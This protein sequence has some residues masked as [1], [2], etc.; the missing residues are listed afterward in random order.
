MKAK[1]HI[2]KIKEEHDNCKSCPEGHLHSQIGFLLKYFEAMERIAIMQT[3]LATMNHMGP[4]GGDGGYYGQTHYVSGE[5]VAANRVDEIFEK[6]MK[7][8]QREI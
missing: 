2:A 1:D 8:E 4:T 5:E 6:D 7:N 3:R